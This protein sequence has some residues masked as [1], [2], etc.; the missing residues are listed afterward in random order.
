MSTTAWHSFHE[1]RNGSFDHSSRVTSNGPIGTMATPCISTSLLR[2][3]EFPQKTRVHSP[4]VTTH[5]TPTPQQLPLTM[6]QMPHGKPQVLR[7]L[8]SMTKRTLM[9]EGAYGVDITLT[10]SSTGDLRVSH[11]TVRHRSEPN[12]P[13]NSLA[14]ST[15]L[16]RSQSH[17]MDIYVPTKTAPI[18]PMPLVS[19]SF[20]EKVVRRL[21]RRQGRRIDG[22]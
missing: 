13:S 18:E 9:V 5:L 16:T 1:G 20:S 15:T 10:T 3:D 7:L 12:L 6:S 21:T 17:D 11:D 22:G 14:P 19:P 4:T 2:V 8:K